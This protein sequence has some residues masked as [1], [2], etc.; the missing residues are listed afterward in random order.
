[1]NIAEKMID[2][3]KEAK[4]S[5]FIKNTSQIFDYI[6]LHGFLDK[7]KSEGY[8]VEMYRYIFSDYSQLTVSTNGFIGLFEPGNEVRLF[9]EN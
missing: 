2:A 5:G 7:I 4:K 6:F 3:L 8:K 1:M 9:N